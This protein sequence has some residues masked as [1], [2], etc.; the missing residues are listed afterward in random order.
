MRAFETG[1]GEAAESGFA[2]LKF[3]FAAARIWDANTGQQVGE[4]LRRESEV[5]TASFSANGARIVTAS[6]DKTARFSSN[7]WL[8]PPAWLPARSLF[9][10]FDPEVAA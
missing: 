6:A 7:V 9:P 10:Y 4:P 8:G 5:Y 2:L 3:S 1:Q